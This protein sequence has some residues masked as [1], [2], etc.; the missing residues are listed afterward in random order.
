MT[1]TDTYPDRGV[2]TPC[3][4]CGTKLHWEHIQYIRVYRVVDGRKIYKAKCPSCDR[5]FQIDGG[6]E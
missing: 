4:D 2:K 3:P 5:Y 1:M 6:R